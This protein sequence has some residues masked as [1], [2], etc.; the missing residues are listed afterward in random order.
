MSFFRKPQEKKTSAVRQDARA[1]KR[2][3]SEKRRGFKM[4]FF[5]GGPDEA[6]QQPHDEAQA[7][8]AAAQKPAPAP[9]GVFGEAVS[10]I[11]RPRITE[12]ATDLTADANAHVFNVA[13]DA[14]KNEVAAGIKEL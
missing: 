10:S 9:K 8:P 7:A 4:P 5:G 6:E 1:G 12:K 11:L 14:T 2:A 13:P 3:L